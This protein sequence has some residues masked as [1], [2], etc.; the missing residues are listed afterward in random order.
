MTI[1]IIILYFNRR[2]E[3]IRLVKHL[4]SIILTNYEIIIVDNASHDDL[5]VELHNIDKNIRYIRLKEN[6]GAVARNSG[7][8]KAKGDIV[9]CLDDDVYGITVN[10][11]CTLIKLFDNE[12]IAAICFKVIDPINN[13][14]TNWSHQCDPTI[15]SNTVFETNRI[16]EGAVAFRTCVL[17]EVGGYFEK[18]FISHEGPDLACRIMNVRKKIVYCPEIVVEHHHSNIGRTSWRRY[19]FDTRNV[20]WLCVRNY[21]VLFSIKKLFWGIFPMLIYSVRDGYLRYWVK[22]IYDGTRELPNIIK[23]R[24][25]VSD[26][27]IKRIKILEANRPTFWSL[28]KKRLFQ[29]SVRI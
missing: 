18:Y 6:T 24:Q 22:G 4:T 7:F 21:P 8:E 29:R 16:T 15:Y 2:N 9:I 5:T 27:V 3:L 1:S 20:I 17:K 11:V 28:A 23:S 14:I 10:D 12:E 19:Y 13:E 25:V 26:E